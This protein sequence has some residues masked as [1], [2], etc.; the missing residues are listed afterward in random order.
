MAPDV[1][2]ALISV[3]EKEGALSREAAEEYVK[4]MQREKRYQRD[5]Y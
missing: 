3:I 1:H 2:E 4:I 5:V